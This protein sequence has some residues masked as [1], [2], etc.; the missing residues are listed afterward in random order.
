MVIFGLVIVMGLLAEFGIILCCIGILFTAMLARV[1]AY[2][3]YKDGVGFK[4]EIL[5]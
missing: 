2:Y 3:I 5:E 4:K 1:P